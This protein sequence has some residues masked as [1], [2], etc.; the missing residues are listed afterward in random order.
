ME[1]GNTGP[2]GS[3]TPI[4]TSNKRAV[5]PKVGGGSNSSKIHP[6]KVHFKIWAKLMSNLISCAAACAD[7]PCRNFSY[8]RCVCLKRASCREPTQQTSWRH[9]TFSISRMMGEDS[10]C[11]SQNNCLIEL[12]HHIYAHPRFQRLGDLHSCL[13]GCCSVVNRQKGRGNS[14]RVIAK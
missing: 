11:Y 6:S 8:T 13:P 4:V 14:D 1:S 12:P 10:T 2:L 5:A 7:L 3:G 9:S